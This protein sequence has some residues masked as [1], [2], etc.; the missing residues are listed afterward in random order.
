[1]TT[2]SMECSFF[3]TWFGMRGVKHILAARTRNASIR[4]D[5]KLAL[6]ALAAALGSDVM[7]THGMWYGLSSINVHVDLT[8]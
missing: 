8:N 7:L 6:N 3:E 1:M 2:R 4:G 5:G